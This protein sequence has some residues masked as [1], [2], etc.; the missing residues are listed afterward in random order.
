MRNWFAKNKENKQAQKCSRCKQAK[1][2]IFYANNFGVV[3]GL[4]KQCR[5]EIGDKE[6]LFPI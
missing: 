2:L 5:K 6:E 1:K 4:C 3:R